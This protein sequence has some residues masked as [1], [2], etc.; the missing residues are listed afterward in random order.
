MLQQPKSCVV[1][2]SL[3]QT[4]LRLIFKTAVVHASPISDLIFEVLQVNIVTE[5]PSH[6]KEKIC[7]SCLAHL[8]RCQDLK[9]KLQ[10]NI[11]KSTCSTALIPRPILNNASKSETPLK[12]LENSESR[13]KRMAKGTPTADKTRTSKKSK[14]ASCAT[15]LAFDNVDE[16]KENI[17]PN[18]I[19]EHSYQRKVPIAEEA[20]T[21]IK[22]VFYKPDKNLLLGAEEKSSLEAAIN[23]GNVN[24]IA[25]VF[26]RTPMLSHAIEGMIIHSVSAQCD[27]ICTRVLEPG[28][29]VLR[30]DVG[31]DNVTDFYSKIIIEMKT[32]IP[33]LLEILKCV[34]SPVLLPRPKALATIATIYSM[35]MNCRVPTMSALQ[36]INS[37]VAVRFHANNALLDVYNQMC[38]T[39]ASSTKLGM[40]DK[41]GK[42]GMQGV[43]SSIRRGIR[44]KLTVDNIDGMMIANQIRGGK[45]NRDYHFT[46]STYY[47]YRYIKN[48]LPS[49]T[50]GTSRSTS[51]FC[52][53]NLFASYFDNIGLSNVC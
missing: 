6:M 13:Y 35:G 1:C 10:Q 46:A 37:C 36:R 32:R 53:S 38:F 31:P 24:E 12:S 41:F 33:F 29:S 28:P 15:S 4:N 39:F 18:E 49:K 40:L 9:R 50:P 8:R 17:T 22:G 20:D 16:N 21:I 19:N 30:Y 14:K 47:V 45:G 48:D 25:N 7:I 11:L 23:H 2:G 26:H 43:V 34:C 5:M 51:N 42:F 52:D 27:R 44:G 3:T